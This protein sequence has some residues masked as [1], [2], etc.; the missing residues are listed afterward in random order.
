MP[1]ERSR[2]R[3]YPHPYPAVFDAL[4][5]ILPTEGCTLREADR[6]SGRITAR[7]RG[8]WRSFGS[9]LTIYVGAEDATATTVVIDSTPRLGLISGSGHER[10]FSRVLAALDRY[11]AYYYPRP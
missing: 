4:V 10:S 8:G 5:A 3:R 2:P 6:Y 11:L 7:A 1:G 9:D